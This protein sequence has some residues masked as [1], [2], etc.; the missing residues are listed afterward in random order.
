MK[1]IFKG[2]YKSDDE[3]LQ[4]IW[5][6][7][8]TIFIFDTNCLFN[9]YRC[10][11][12]TREDITNLMRLI[13]N[14]IWIPFQVGYEYQTNRKQVIYDS[15]NS[16][17]KVKESLKEIIA[18]TPESLN[19][20]KKNLY[21]SLS[22]EFKDLI[23]EISDPINNFIESNIEPRIDQKK[24]IA[25]S[26]FIRNDIDTIVGDK[27]A[28][29]PSQETINDINTKGEDRYAKLIPPG[30]RDAKKLDESHYAGLT[31][32]KKFGDL[33]LWMEIINKA[34]EDDVKNIVFV[35]DDNKEDWW[36]IHR[37]KTHGAHAQLA[38]EIYAETNLINFKMINQSSFLIDGSKYLEN[39]KVDASS[40]EE[41]KAVYSIQKENSEVDIQKNSNL[42]YTRNI[43]NEKIFSHLTSFIKNAS[44]TSRFDLTAPLGKTN[45]N[46][47]STSLTR[48]LKLEF[49]AIKLCTELNELESLDFDEEISMH[50][51]NLKDTIFNIDSLKKTIEDIL[52]S[53]YEGD[54]DFNSLISKI[55]HT[56]VTAR[57]R[58]DDAK[59]FLEV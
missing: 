18:K 17:E 6:S 41:M 37:G 22:S 36:Y 42:D 21:S 51:L 29:P 24:S 49:E 48:L 19:L 50:L 52:I 9:L 47:L 5:R 30:Y 7:G 11:T 20:I 39:A 14:R 58:I 40:V 25:E 43:F 10:E 38:A 3:E 31:L 53:H 13:S 44:P 16:L 28:P 1:E 2:F 59:Q 57:L 35:C 23:K 4:D 27:C 55:R 12:Q 15:V 46:K 56:S 33:Y 34:R 8:D 26:D 54:I 32:K 45:H